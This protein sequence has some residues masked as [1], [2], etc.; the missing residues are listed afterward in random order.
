[1]RGHLNN[2]KA[3]KATIKNGWLHTGD[4]G[5]VYRCG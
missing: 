3:T 5:K 1:M 4:F 2:S